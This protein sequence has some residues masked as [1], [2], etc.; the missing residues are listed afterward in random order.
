MRLDEAAFVL[1]RPKVPSMP[2]RRAFVRAG[3]TFAAGL[4]VGGAGDSCGQARRP[5][6]PQDPSQGHGCEG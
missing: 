1:A 2:T 4:T 5:R 3:C 6:S